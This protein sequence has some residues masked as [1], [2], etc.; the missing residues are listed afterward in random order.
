MACEVLKKRL[1]S[2]EALQGSVAQFVQLLVYLDE[3]EQ[4]DPFVE[5]FNLTEDDLA[6]PMLY[7][8]GP[9]GEPVDSKLG[10]PPGDE[11]PTLLTESLKK[12]AAKKAG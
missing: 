8:V 11:L 6:A 9:D 12:V 10:F 7:I 2:E 5:K 3:S 1:A 4:L